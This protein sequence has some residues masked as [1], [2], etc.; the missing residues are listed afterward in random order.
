[1]VQRTSEAHGP[2]NGANDA[3]S[4]HDEQERHAHPLS[5]A[6]GGINPAR[7]TVI[8]SLINNC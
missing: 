4:S 8:V 6:S 3:R 5:E 2:N 1:M 7:G